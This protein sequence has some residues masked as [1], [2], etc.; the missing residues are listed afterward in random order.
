MRKIQPT[1]AWWCLAG[2]LTPEQII[3]TTAS[4]EIPGIEFAPRE[5]WDAIREAGLRIVG[6]RAQDDISNGLNDP[7]KH[8]RIDRSISRDEVHDRISNESVRL[9]AQAPLAHPVRNAF[10][11]QMQRDRL[12]AFR[13]QVQ[14]H[15]RVS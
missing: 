15:F 4:L 9:V 14:V 8:D 7:A 11:H 6:V 1:T 2:V 12:R 10:L 13:E 5:Q 3:E